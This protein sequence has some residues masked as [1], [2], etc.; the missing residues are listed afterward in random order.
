MLL[1]I[2]SVIIVDDVFMIC[3][4]VVCVCGVMLLMRCVNCGV[5][6]VRMMVLVC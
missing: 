6:I 5:G 3:W 2:V 1:G 4:V